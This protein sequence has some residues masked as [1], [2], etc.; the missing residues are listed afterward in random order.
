MTPEKKASSGF[1]GKVKKAQW[2]FCEAPQGCQP[3]WKQAHP[4]PYRKQQ[5]THVRHLSLS[6]RHLSST[7]D[8]CEWDQKG[9]G[10]TGKG[11]WAKVLL[12][13]QIPQ[14]QAF[15][16]GF[17][18]TGKTDQNWNRRVDFEIFWGFGEKGGGQPWK[19]NLK[20]AVLNS[21][22]ENITLGTEGHHRKPTALTSGCL[23]AAMA[24]HSWWL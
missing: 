12:A 14:C 20:Y 16:F 2:G 19:E 17:W 1:Y 6:G 15:T 21:S 8:P 24:C 13:L 22:E 18:L 4:Q 3:S 23:P 5:E 10:Q 11:L 9:Q 7:N